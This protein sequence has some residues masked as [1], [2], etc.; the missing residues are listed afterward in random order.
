[1]GWMVVIPRYQHAS[2]IRKDW[3]HE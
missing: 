2:P 3:V 1:V